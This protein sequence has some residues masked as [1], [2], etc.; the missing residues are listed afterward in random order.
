[1]QG[2]N[3]LCV[4]ELAERVH[5]VAQCA[6]KNHRVLWDYRDLASQLVQPDFGNVDSVDDNAPTFILAFCHFK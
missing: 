2:H 5:V 1:M 6:R 3:D 4:S